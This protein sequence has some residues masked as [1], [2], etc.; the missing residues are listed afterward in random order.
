MWGEA[1]EGSSEQWAGGAPSPHTG[2]GLRCSLSAVPLRTG[3]AGHLRGLSGAPEDFLEEAPLSWTLK[4]NVTMEPNGREN[5]GESRGPGTHVGHTAASP[6]VGIMPACAAPHEPGPVFTVEPVTFLG[7][8]A[9][10][11]QTR[12]VRCRGRRRV[13][14]PEGTAGSRRAA[15]PR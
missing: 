4:L 14:W 1:R 15:Y 13:W 8:G 9:P 6:G 10:I 3:S 11:L 7:G 12:R 2:P 5:A